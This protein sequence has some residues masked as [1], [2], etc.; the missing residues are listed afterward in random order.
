MHGI[1]MW[2]TVTDI[3]WSV[4]MCLSISWKQ[5]W[6]K[7]LKSL[8]ESIEPCIRWKPD[9]PQKRQLCG[10]I[11]Y[12]RWCNYHKWWLFGMLAAISVYSFFEW[13]FV[14]HVILPEWCPPSVGS[15]R[16]SKI[17]ELSMH[18]GLYETLNAYRHLNKT[19]YWKHPV[20]TVGLGI[21]ILRVWYFIMAKLCKN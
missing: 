14:V 21:K 20:S 16:E 17:Y 3:M 7:K 12:A 2:P 8:L 13:S 18:T 5:K 10:S 6:L 19:T 15:L 1:R 9:A 11:S 4:C